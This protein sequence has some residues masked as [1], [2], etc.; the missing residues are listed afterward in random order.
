MR[1]KLS[2]SDEMSDDGGMMDERSV[3]ELIKKMHEKKGETIDYLQKTFSE[4]ELAKLNKQISG[5][6]HVKNQRL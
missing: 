1:Y 5:E 4:E 6:L 2:M 3:D